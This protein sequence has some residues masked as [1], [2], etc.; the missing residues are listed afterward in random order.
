MAGLP[1]AGRRACHTG[2]APAAALPRGAPESAAASRSTRAARPP[3]AGAA[4]VLLYCHG[5]P[6]CSLEAAV[7]AD[8]AEALGVAIVAPDR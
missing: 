7:F 8:A 6:S 1:G 3:P 2:A 4:A 5:V